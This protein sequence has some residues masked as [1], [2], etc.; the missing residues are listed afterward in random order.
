MKK[1]YNHITINLFF[2]LWFFLI[3]FFL[4]LNTNKH[5]D[6][7]DEAFYILNVSNPTEIIATVTNFGFLN[8]FI[9]KDLNSS[10]V[11]YRIIGILLLILAGFFFS[12][13]FIIFFKNR[14]KNINIDKILFILF[15]SVTI[16]NFYKHWLVTPSY[17]YNIFLSILVILSS[18]FF[19]LN[20]E[21]NLLNLAFYQKIKSLFYCSIFFSVAIAF[22][23][24]SKITFISFLLLAFLFL[25]YFSKYKI[26]TIIFLSLNLLFSLFIVYL[27]III[28]YENTDQFIFSNQLDYQFRKSLNA[29]YKLND[30]FSNLYLNLFQALEFFIT[31]YFKLIYIVTSIFF[32]FL[33]KK[34]YSLILLKNLFFILFIFFFI[35]DIT[36]PLFSLFFFIILNIIFS[37][38]ENY[39]FYKKNT[40]LFYILFFLLLVPFSFSLGTNNNIISHTFFLNFIYFFLSLIILSVNNFKYL[41]IF[42]FIYIFLCFFFTTHNLYSSYKLPY[43]FKDKVDTSNLVEV[44]FNIGG[45]I[46]IEQ[47]KAKLFNKIKSDYIL[48]GWIEGEYL[49]DFTGSNPGIIMLVGGKFISVPWLMGYWPGS[50]EYIYLTLKNFNDIEKIKKSWIFTSDDTKKNFNENYILDNL[51]INFSSTY[52]KISSYKDEKGITL[53]LWKPILSN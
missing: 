6:F 44:N 10:I 37:L 28:F 38:K 52:E 27:F 42:Q 21:K 3:I 1:S 18:I 8:S 17:N 16:L 2:A 13:N 5:F 20:C 39:F 35:F 45:K 50:E 14:F 12:Y 29:G 26:N 51:N 32:I 48:N 49:I 53:S 40:E 34:K 41:R 46:F 47:K 25:F 22:G 43:G 11:A 23:L 24:L 19:Y 31:S 33:L 7:A 15:I 36:T 30:M 4:L 9:F